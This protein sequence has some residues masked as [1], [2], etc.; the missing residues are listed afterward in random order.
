MGVSTQSTWGFFCLVASMPTPAES[1]P[2][3]MRQVRVEKLCL[4]ISVGESGDRLTR[5]SK[6]LEALTGQQPVFSKACLTVR[7]FGIRRNEKIACRCSVSG[8]KAME[9]I[10]KGLAVKEY[11]LRGNNFSK[12]GTFGFGVD[13][14]IDLGLKYDPSIGIYGLD[15]FVVLSRPGRRVSKRRRA[16]AS[17]GKHHRVSKEDALDW[18]RTTYNGVVLP[19]KAK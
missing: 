10:E 7:Q 11:E 3:P 18:F 1:K 16:R 2:N 15:F 9:L 19:P 4:N 17:V 12:E 8:P 6:V 5:A 13:E 14:H